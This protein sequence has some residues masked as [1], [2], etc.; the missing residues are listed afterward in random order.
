MNLNFLALAVPFFVGLMLL[1]YMVSVRKGKQYFQFSEAIAN[2]NVGIAE[3][4]SDVF[5]TGVFYYFFSWI[6]SNYA[7]F[8]IPTGPVTFV[9][10]FL[11]TDLIWYWYHRF[12]H[13]VNII[14][15]AHV[16]HHQSEDFNFT[17]AA[18][19]TVLQAA[20]RALFWSVLP[21]LGFSPAM[22][23]TILLIH[24]AYPFFTHTQMVGKLGFL[25]YFLVTPS[26]HRVHH[27][28]NP[29]YLDKN[30]GDVLIIWD[31]IFGTFQQEEEK[32]VFGL[33][34]SL[35]SYSF[36]WQHFHFVLEMV[37]AFKRAHGWKQKWVVLFGKPDAIDPRIRQYLEK[38]L[39]K[40]TTINYPSP[41]L[42]RYIGIQT[43]ITLCSLFFVILFEHYQST[44]QLSLAA[45]FIIVSVIN[46]GAMLEQKKWN[47]HLEYL[48]F[49]LLACFLYTF[50]P[51]HW[52]AVCVISV[53]MIS[54]FYYKSI[55]ERYY[56]ILYHEAI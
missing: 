31:K 46:T 37:I 11:A 34:K 13:E 33:T 1:E 9:V 4:L 12:G 36:L 39:L 30:Y 23:A 50:P 14:W 8:S 47:F 18:R 29:A 41:I 5:T 17:V 48:R 7:I 45:F 40:N 38:K 49:F 3:R 27:S 19:I 56:S 43:L 24:G 42:Y 28:S 44:L 26:H 54:L 25:E 16:V 35:N 10:L 21:L 53:V 2:I 52:M 15:S 32:P 20:A 6:Y 51:F 22:T 55:S